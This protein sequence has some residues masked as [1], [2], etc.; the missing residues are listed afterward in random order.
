MEG[1]SLGG[2]GWVLLA[3]SL[4]LGVRLYI[5]YGLKEDRSEEDWRA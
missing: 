1:L 3:V 2:W 5:R 4:H